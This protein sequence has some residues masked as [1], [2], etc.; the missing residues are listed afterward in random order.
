MD[1]PDRFQAEF[2]QARIIGLEVK[3]PSRDHDP[4]IESKI[5]R[6]DQT[7]FT[8]GG[9]GIGIGKLDPDLIGGFGLDIIR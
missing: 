1:I 6:M 4:V 8:L 3:N 7:A 9:F 5:V 2:K